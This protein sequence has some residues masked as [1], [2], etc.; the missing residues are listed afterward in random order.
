MGDELLLFT[1]NRAAMLKS[2]GELAWQ[3]TL[4]TLPALD[5]EDNEP[6][7]PVAPVPDDLPRPN[8]RRGRGFQFRRIPPPVD[9]EARPEQ[10]TQVRVAGDRVIFAT[11]NGRVTAIDSKGNVLWQ[12]RLN[13]RPIDRLLASDDFVV[14]SAGDEVS[15]TL[16][17]LDL[18]TGQILFRRSYTRDGQWPI[19]VDLSPDGK[20]VYLTQDQLC[21]KDL[22]E[23]GDK[24]SFAIPGVR[25]DNGRP[26]FEGA[27]LPDH[28]VIAQ[29]RIL[30][31]AENGEFMHIHSLD[32]GRVITSTTPDGQ[33]VDGRLPTE[34]RDWRVRL[35]TAGPRV[36]VVGQRATLVAYNLDH[37]GETWDRFTERDGTWQTRDAIIGKNHVLVL[38]EPTPGAQPD[39]PATLLRMNFY[40]RM[41]SKQGRESGLNE[42]GVNLTDPTGI[43]QWQAVEGGLYYLTGDNK[44]HFLRGAK[45]DG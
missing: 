10:I 33:E 36:Y 37:F 8:F 5:A 1:P 39:R 40:S 21:A 31:I 32:T 12:S 34:A 4:Q 15:V 18:G 26:A 17:A 16:C 43:K 24:L 9:V 14:F 11:S 45:K 20:I 41:L 29:G 35:Q 3:V 2:N 42:F 30:V 44:L 22:F 38:D 27:M 28:L 7:P 19:N 25:R 6:T 23:P 13:S